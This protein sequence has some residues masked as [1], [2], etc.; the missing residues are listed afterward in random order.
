VTSL[1]HSV[2]IAIVGAGLAG[3][4][5]ALTAQRAGLSVVLIEGSDRVGGR[6]TSDVI[7]GFI[8]DRGFQVFNPA[9]PH[10]KSLLNYDLLSLRSFAPGIR[11]VD[12]DHD[13]FLANVLRDV[14]YAPTMVKQLLHGGLQETTDFI[15]FIAYAGNATIT[16]RPAVFETDARSSLKQAGISDSFI[17]L[18]LR[19][20]LTGVF[21]EGSLES[22]RRFL[23][24]VVEYFVK[25][26]PALPADGMR[27]ISEQLAHN[28]HSDSLHLN[29]WVHRVA[30][31][32][33]VTDGGTLSAQ[34][35]I[36]ATDMDTASAWLGIDSR[37]WNSVTTWY[38][39][40][41]GARAQLNGGKPQLV[42]DASD[43]PVINSIPLSHAAAT[44]APVGKHLI[45]SSTLGTDTS[46][47]MEQRVRRQLASMY[48]TDTSDWDLIAT[49]PIARAL[50]RTLPPFV[51]RSDSKIDDGLFVAGDTI[52]LPS[53]DS[54]MESGMRAARAAI[55]DIRTP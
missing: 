24:F 4:S 16:S 8:C 1:P 21:L 26:V 9:Y 14:T 12:G 42:V 7:D 37:G 44:Y 15:K 39:V 18:Y 10:S 45:S 36:V 11:I 20:F 43:G 29:T 48:R 50:P 35:V 51:A 30:P 46:S 31:H 25:G 19:P 2:D 49:Y 23:D 47:E 28:L 27:A 52:T 41:D 53:I 3:L 5:A 32:E 54:A 13:K 33:V 17:E 38:H 6:V 34:A 55:A 22:S 40:A